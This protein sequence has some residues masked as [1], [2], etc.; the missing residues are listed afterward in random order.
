MDVTPSDD[1]S[2]VFCGL[3]YPSGH[4]FINL[5]AEDDIVVVEI[6]IW[7][8]WDDYNRSEYILSVCDV[9]RSAFTIVLM[10]MNRIDIY[11]RFINVNLN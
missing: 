6:N 1:I 11:C 8:V 7:W 9:S 4:G 2:S 5:V 3:G 10:L